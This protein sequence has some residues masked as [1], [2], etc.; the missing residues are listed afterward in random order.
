MQANQPMIHLM[1]EMITNLIFSLMKKFIKN[2][3]LTNTVNGNTKSKDLSELVS[4]DLVSNQKKLESISIG[5]RAREIL[6][7][8]NIETEAREEF[9][10]KCRAF[11][12][13]STRY[14]IDKLPVE[15][16]FLKD[17]QYLHPERRSS[18]SSLNSISR[19]AL[20]VGNAL[21]NHIKT[22]FNVSDDATVSE[23]CDLVRDQWA[24]SIQRMQ[25]C[26]FSKISIE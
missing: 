23:V 19:L 6:A 15:N 4:I 10:K 24:H 13:C 8:I 9:F 12:E 20:V 5:T 25:D 7:D 26:S 14:L 18:I 17:A 21:K 16:Q 22:V 3:I 1:L 11:F 2:S